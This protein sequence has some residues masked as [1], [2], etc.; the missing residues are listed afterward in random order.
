MKPITP[1]ITSK[2][3]VISS[4]TAEDISENRSVDNNSSVV[5]NPI[6]KSIWLGTACQTQDC[7]RAH[8][9]R[10][11]NQD[12][13]VLDQ[14]LPCWKV[15]QCRS[16]HGNPKSKKKT[17]N[18]VYRPSTQTRA[19][20]PVG[21]T[22]WPSHYGPQ[23]PPV[24]VNQNP[25]QNQWF[26]PSTSQAAPHLGKINNLSGNESA[27]LPRVGNQMRGNSKLNEVCLAIELVR[28]MSSM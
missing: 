13:F 25:I 7:P 21:M 20:K 17:Q 9:S 12:C 2:N 19:K 26:K 24:W 8:P 11:K 28:L 22:Y 6:C 14:G 27:A 5:L 4:Q 3:P 15:L 1:C 10:C 16:W 18:R 23:A